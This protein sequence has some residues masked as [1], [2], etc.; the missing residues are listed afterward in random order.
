METPKS[1]I[2]GWS[3]FVGQYLTHFFPESDLY[4]SVNIEELRGKTYNTIYFSAMPAEKWKINQNPT[5]D[6]KLLSY[7][8]DLLS[9]VSCEK[10]ILISTV[11]VLDCTISQS[12]DGSIF[13]EHPYGQNRR[14]LEEFI[15][16]RFTTHII[17]RLPGLFGKGLKKNVIYDLLHNNQLENICLDSEFQWYSLEHLKDDIEYCRLNNI[18]LIQPVSVPIKTSSIIERFFPDKL[19]YCKGTRI[20]KYQLETFYLLRADDTVLDEIGRYIEWYQCARRVVKQ[21]AVSNIAWKPEQFRDV[22]K[23]LKRYDINQIEMAFTTLRSWA[24][25][26]DEFISEVRK[27]HYIYPSCQSILYDTGIE[28]FKEQ[29]RFIEHYKSVLELCSKL[30]ISR[31]VFGSPTGRHIYSSTEAERVSLFRHLGDESSAYGVTLCIE[32]NSSKYGC[33]W[34]TNLE[35]TF[36]FVRIVGH[37]NIK[38]NFDFGNYIME[39]DST[40]ITTEIVSHIRN[41]QISSPFLGSIDSSLYD[42]YVAIWRALVTAGYDGGISLEMRKSNMGTFIESCGRVVEILTCSIVG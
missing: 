16:K 37:P 2:I 21:M 38:I 15:Q 22:D 10:F 33:T 13:A 12:E 5:D 8:Y 26:D 27:N 11:D 7:F 19:S 14:M 24:D 39:N 42:P 32:P 40:T 20:V 23:I 18:Q 6:V 9:D 1:A 28:I 36:G 35:E 41:V 29:S 34:L 17:L 31:I 4:N 25:W 3:G 30:G